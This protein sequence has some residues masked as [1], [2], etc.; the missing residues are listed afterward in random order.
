[1]TSRY[2]LVV[3][4]WVHPGQEAAFEAFEREAAQRM[5]SYGGRI[6]AA[7]RT[8][9]NGLATGPGDTIAYEVHIVSFP[10][11]AAAEA[12]GN[13]PATLASRERRTGIISQTMVVPG[14]EAGPY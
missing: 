3:S 7:V 1:M 5:A 12:Y 9:P 8:A 4:L 13:D 2:S 11:K 10:D 6:D 14:R